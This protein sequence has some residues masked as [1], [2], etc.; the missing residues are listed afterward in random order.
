M[1]KCI[2][3]KRPKSEFELNLILK[4]AYDYAQRSDYETALSI[5]NWLIQDTST[6]IAGYRKRA[7]IHEHMGDV[8]KAI[9]DL[10][11]VIS[12]YKEEPADYY[13]LGLL[14]LK[15]GCLEDAIDSFSGAIESGNKANNDYYK[16]GS[17]L[18]RAETYLKIKEYNKAISDCNKLP[19]GYKT[20]ISGVGMRSKEEI[21]DESI[22][23]ISKKRK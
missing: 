21:I 22:H 17:Y 7:A 13:G 10:K 19:A 4:K 18:F 14:Q 6:K 1:T 12:K 11:H 8:K 9:S 2:Y 15:H 23:L 20:Y 3:T 5:C 16:Y